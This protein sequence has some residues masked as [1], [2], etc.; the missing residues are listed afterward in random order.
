MAAASVELTTLPAF[1]TMARWLVFPDSG[2]A[3]PARRTPDIENTNRKRTK[4]AIDG[5]FQII[6]LKHKIRN[7]R[8]TSNGVLI[9]SLGGA[10]QRVA[11]GLVSR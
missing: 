2:V 7:A 3:G 1:P 4:F 5:F 6:I 10:K 9:E 8:Q 11:V